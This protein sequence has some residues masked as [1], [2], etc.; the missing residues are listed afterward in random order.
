MNRPHLRTFL[1]ADLYRYGGV[2]T[3]F[4]LLKA[5]SPSLPAFRYTYLLR[6]ASAFPK[7]SI[8]GFFYRAL[9]HHYSSLYGFQILPNT[10]IGKGLYI[11]HRGTVVINGGAELGENCTLT[12]LV[13]IGQ[14]NRGEKKGCPRIG[15]SVWIGAG[16][17][18]VGK[19]VIGDNVL[20]APNSY[21]N[22]D[23]PSNS[24]VT[25]N[26]AV[27]KQHANA[28]EGYVNFAFSAPDDDS[29]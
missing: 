6:H 24:I 4:Y 15:D 22:V 17:V 18:V 19:I 12:H 11:G 20:I 26:P 8:R 5:L 23:V 21:V 2:K 1:E 9:L 7:H 28:T 16:A 14:A 3:R 29:T 10:R 25:G 27:V 13:T